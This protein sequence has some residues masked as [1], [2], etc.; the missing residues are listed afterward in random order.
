MQASILYDVAAAMAAFTEHGRGAQVLTPAAKLRGEVLPQEVL[1]E[2]PGRAVEMGVNAER[3][4]ARTTREHR[5]GL[6][7]NRDLDWLYNLNG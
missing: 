1:Q 4:L 6:L 2:L 7:S 3:H 5:P